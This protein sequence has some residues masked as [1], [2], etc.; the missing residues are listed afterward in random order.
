MNL[1]D[2]AVRHSPTGGRVLIT[3][4]EK[5]GKIAIGIR[6]DGPGIPPE[7]RN[8]LFCK[9]GAVRARRRGVLGGTGLGLA[10]CK[11]AV[12][13]H[14]GSITLESE[15]GEGSLFSITLPVSSPELKKRSDRYV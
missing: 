5:G 13:A 3:A 12:E 2:N 4:E 15:P 14:G 7:F 1:V 9:Y 10:F 8:E 6:D 11:L